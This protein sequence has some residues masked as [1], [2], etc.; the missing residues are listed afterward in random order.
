M[1]SNKPYLL[2][3]LFDWI[4]D[5]SCTPYIIVDATLPF[6]EV[7]KDYIEEGQI[8]LNILPSATD[9]LIIAND[10]VSF[11]ARFSGIKYDITIPIGAIIAIYAAENAQGMAFT[12]E[13]LPENE[14]SK[15][16]I[17]VPSKTT[18]SSSPTP[19]TQDKKNS[20]SSTPTTPRPPLKIIK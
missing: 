14:F 12:T 3:A 2:R 20:Q 7:P 16:E 10:W 1:S 6:V 15:K 19:N 8:T 4:I 13:A 18:P 11:S 17:V 5:N 9:N